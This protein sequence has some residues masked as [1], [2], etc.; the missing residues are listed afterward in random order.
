MAV[1][2]PLL[3]ALSLLLLAAC[4]AKAA[5]TAAYE[6]PANAPGGSRSSPPPIHLDQTS[7]LTVDGMGSEE[8][9][10]R[11]ALG[12]CEQPGIPWPVHALTPSEVAKIG[13]V[14]LELWIGPDKEARHEEEW[15]FEE[16]DLP[17]PPCHFSLTHSR[18]QTWIVEA[19]GRTTFIDNVTHQVDVGQGDPLPW[20]AE[21]L[22]ASDA[23]VS[24][25]ESDELL[26]KA[27]WRM[28]GVTNSNG[29][30]CEIWQDPTGDEQDCNW[31]G[32][33]QWGY[34]SEGSWL[35]DGISVGPS[36]VGSGIV[37]WA[38]PQLGKGAYRVETQAFSVGQPLDP[39]AFQLPANAKP[40]TPP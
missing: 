32:G 15:H 16:A 6:T 3:A 31:I 29:A 23:E 9:A 38:H 22:S 7:V 4:S 19:N 28:L 5:P 13:R 40:A 39:R 20:A 30:Q 11:Y 8:K 37:L 25:R 10:Y 24:R 14:H 36:I 21:Q 18:D 27:G 33:R 34:S 26:R 12:V 17:V 2:L 1:G 35:H